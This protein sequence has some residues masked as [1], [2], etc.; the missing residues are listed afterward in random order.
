MLQPMQRERAMLHMIRYAFDVVFYHSSDY[1][2]I[3]FAFL[4]I[5]L[6]FFARLL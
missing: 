2:L 4:L 6:S 5:C 1:A 3:T